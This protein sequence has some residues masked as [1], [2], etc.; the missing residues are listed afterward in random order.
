MGHKNGKGSI[1][2][3]VY[4]GRIRLRWRYEGKR[5]SLNVGVDN[6]KQHIEARKLIFKIERDIAYDEFDVTLGKYKT[7]TPVA[8]TRT[9]NSMS[10]VQSFEYWVCNYR[11]MDCEVN[12]DY[13]SLRNTIRKWGRVDANNILSLLNK[14]KYNPTTFNRKLGLLKLFTRWLVKQKVWTVDPLDEVIKRKVVKTVKLKRTP[15]TSQEI[16]A[17][18]EAVKNDSFSSKGSRYPH[19]HYYPFLYFLFKTGVRPAEAVGLRVG[20]IDANKKVIHIKEVLARTVKGTNAANRVRRQTKNGKD[21]VLPL[22]KDLYDVIMPILTNKQSDDLV[23]QSFSKRA[24]DDRM[25]QRRVFKPVLKAL[26]IAV[27]DLYACR[28]TFGSRCIDQGISPVMTAFLMGNNPQTALRNYTHQI[29][30]PK[31]LPPI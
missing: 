28:H 18:L 25:F 10:I 9:P 2:V 4:N 24:I 5:Y 15:F 7:R 12:I 14:E 23:F 20:S 22:N 31:D 29:S 6:S 21:R 26:R 17:I 19:S 16:T 3:S 11:Q 27:R 30:L 1:A 13:Y 8:K